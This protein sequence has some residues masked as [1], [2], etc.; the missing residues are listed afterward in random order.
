[1]TDDRTDLQLRAGSEWR[2][3]PAAIL[4]G[5][6]F[7]VDDIA[8][9]SSGVWEVLGGTAEDAA[10]LPI[11][12]EGAQRARERL[13]GVLAS[14]AAYLEAI[15][16]QN[17]GVA[18]S[19]VI[20]FLKG[21]SSAKRDRQRAELCIK[22][23]QRYTT[24]NE[25]IGFFGPLTWVPFGVDP[26]S[27]AEPG[28]ALLSHR[29]VL[30]EGWALDAF[31]SGLSKRLALRRFSPPRLAPF[32][33]F[34][35]GMVRFP[36]SPPMPIPEEDARLL[37]ACDGKRAP[38]E[39]ADLLGLERAA[40]EASLDGLASRGMV[41][42]ELGVPL[43]PW[44]DQALRQTIER[45]VDD[46]GARAEALSS[47]DQL[48]LR[49]AGVEQAAGDAAALK[50][51][52]TALQAFLEQNSEA[53]GEERRGAYAGR[54]P[55]YE[56]CRRD[57]DVHIGADVVARLAG[58]LEL[59]LQSAAW[60]VERCVAAYTVAF[61]EIVAGADEMPFVDFWIQVLQ[62][63]L[64]ADTA[65]EIMT[66]EVAELQ[67]RWA[68]ILTIPADAGARLDLTCDQL[69]SAVLAAFPRSASPTPRYYAP[70]VLIAASSP[71]ALRDGRY[72]LVIGELHPANSLTAIV[73]MMMYSDVEDVERRLREDHAVSP[74]RMLL[75]RG[76][77]TRLAGWVHRVHEFS[78]PA[79]PDAPLP[80][81]G[82]VF[83]PGDLTVRRIE[84]KLVVVASDGHRWDLV[85]F[86]EYGLVNLW[87]VAF[88][89]LPRDTHRPRITIDGVVV[90]RQRW[91][92]RVSE[93]QAFVQGEQ[94]ERVL[95]F[96]RHFRATMPRYVFCV[97][98]GEPKPLFIDFDN[99]LLVDLAAR[100]IKQ[101]ATPGRLEEDVVF[102]EMLPA[103][104]EVWLRDAAGRGYT[105][106]LRICVRG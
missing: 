47:L 103:A 44:P 66:R 73:P 50:V 28:P 87:A 53:S 90:A 19:A 38:R 45:Y 49:R 56:D 37:A 104:D 75:P 7:P 25:T 41:L 96:A 54:E 35:P 20:P 23:L 10:L 71:E 85:D 88:R 80:E 40:V 1:M 48:E 14:N 42:W 82:Q 30:L 29:A 81:R 3:W 76:T 105:S 9:A 64:I 65:P 70:D 16:W 55:A 97:I 8:A 52:V 22:Y 101:A 6:G 5:A 43:S 95:S 2:V 21:A 79:T 60:F 92:H 77:P 78:F 69:R 106:E 15:T 91:C 27:S 98:P 84:G 61:E 4:R 58:P 12:E 67:R 11:L 34:P 74:V 68:E 59:L 46:A 62:R 93:L 72:S 63:R 99:V 33:G 102:T 89:W 83:R 57:V 18:D 26:V 86:V 24:K 31:A 94:A 39:I 51:A 13:R 36:F 32:L 17:P 100:R